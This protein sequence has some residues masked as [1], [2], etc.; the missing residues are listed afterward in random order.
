MDT[1]FVLNNHKQVIDVLSNN[2][3]NPSAPFFDDT[4]KAELDTGA[5]SYEFTTINN[6]RTNATLEVGN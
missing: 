2:G 1:I 5:E 3:S 4:Y 6:P